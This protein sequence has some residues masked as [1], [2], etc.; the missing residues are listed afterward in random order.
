MNATWH[1]ASD[2]GKQSEM[3]ARINEVVAKM[4]K[5]NF[6]FGLMIA[7]KLSN[8]ATTLAEKFRLHPCQQ[9]KLI[10]CQVCALKS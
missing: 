3:E 6:L 2:V 4:K 8:I 7:E 1:E 10:V 9:L 5:F